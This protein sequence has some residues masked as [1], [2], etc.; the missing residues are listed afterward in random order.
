MSD[1]PKTFYK[2]FC[3]MIWKTSNDI[4]TIACGINEIKSVLLA[5]IVTILANPVAYINIL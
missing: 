2:P 1:M 3:Y 5:A 4:S